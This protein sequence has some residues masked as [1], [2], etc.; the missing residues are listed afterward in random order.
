MINLD[1][2]YMR[3][4]L[5]LA[6]EAGDAGEVPVGA[7][8]VLNGQI[9][10]RGRNRTEGFHDPTAHAEMEAITAA[11]DALNEKRLEGAT[12]Y[13]TLEPCTMCTGALVLARVE[14][15]VFG[16]EDPKTGACGTV[17]RLHDEPHLN[18]QFDVTG[19]ILAGESEALLKEF[20]RNL[21]RKKDEG[22]REKR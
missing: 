6:R 8:V 1:E 2:H 21:R 10:G 13:V 3:Q 5:K 18:H 11:A 12:L 7:V 4:A 14:R 22:T 17:F 9:L 20:F 15:V 16:A 19:G